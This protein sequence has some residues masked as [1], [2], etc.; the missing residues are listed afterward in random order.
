MR[1]KAPPG[2]SPFGSS[3]ALKSG[4]PRQPA[5]TEAER[6]G[7]GLNLLDAYLPF[8]RMM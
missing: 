6:G 7:N 3:Q 8:F 1:A 2:E 5:E 4:R